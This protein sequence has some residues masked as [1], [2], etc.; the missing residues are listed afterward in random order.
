MIRTLVSRLLRQDGHMV[1]V[2]GSVEEALTHPVSE[3]QAL[4]I[5]VRLGSGRGTD[6]IERM[7]AQDPS[8]PARCLLLS[9]GIEDDLPSDVALL[10]KPFSGEDLATAVHGLRAG[11]PTLGQAEPPDVATARLIT[12]GH[13][14]GSGSEPPAGRPDGPAGRPAGWEGRRRVQGQGY[15]DEDWFGPR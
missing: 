4:I 3:Y 5:D 15:P 9:G 12:S 8:I 7:R 13:A 6:L 1:D 10:R 14:D 2:A 11:C